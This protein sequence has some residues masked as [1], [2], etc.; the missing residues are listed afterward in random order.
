MQMSKVYVI[1]K[2]KYLNEFNERRKLKLAIVH[3]RKS[4]VLKCFHSLIIYTK[5][6]HKKNIQKG[7]LFL[8]SIIKCLF[9]LLIFQQN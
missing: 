6:R 9:N 2:N 3:H 4:L 5:Y 1:W 7:F 8:L